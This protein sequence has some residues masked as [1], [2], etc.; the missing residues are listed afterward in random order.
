MTLK[1]ALQDLTPGEV[2]RH[3]KEGECDF[4]EIFI[5]QNLTLRF[6]DPI[7]EINSKNIGSDK[8]EK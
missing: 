7:M 6:S 1:E 4:V 2:I 3:G 8:W 5:L